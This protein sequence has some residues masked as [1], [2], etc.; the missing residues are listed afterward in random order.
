MDTELDN[1]HIFAEETENPIKN[2]GSP[3]CWDTKQKMNAF[4]EIDIWQN[5]E[6][7]KFNL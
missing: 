6:D 2:H 4:M 1:Y 5:H 3:F 7:S